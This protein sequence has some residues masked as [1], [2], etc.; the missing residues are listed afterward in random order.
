L[1]PLF[2]L[3]SRPGFALSFGWRTVRVV[4]FSFD[5]TVPCWFVLL[6]SLHVVVID[7]DGLKV[8]RLALIVTSGLDVPRALFTTVG[9]GRLLVG[10]LLV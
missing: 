1:C 4:I 8:E 6:T 2:A 5:C 3:P 7:V 9:L 10:A